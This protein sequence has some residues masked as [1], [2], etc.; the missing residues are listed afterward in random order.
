MST[1]I[2][3]RLKTLEIQSPDT[4]LKDSLLLGFDTETTGTYAGKDAIVSASLVLRNPQT[5]YAGDTV[6]EWIIAP[7]IPMNPLASKVNGFT[8]DFLEAHGA[9]QKTAILEITGTIVQ[10]QLKNIPLLAYNAP[11]DVD[12]LNG[13]L[14]RIGRAPIV[15]EI[16]DA[17]TDNFLTGTQRELI[18]ADPLVIDRAVS[19]RSGRR[20]LT[21]TTYYYGVQPHGSFH[22]ATA[23]TVAAVDLIEPICAAYPQVGVITVAGLMDW[24]RNAHETWK[25][26]FNAYL[27]SQG[28]PPVRDSW[29][30]VQR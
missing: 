6:A 11:F 23:D 9:D 16:N 28:R 24:Q 1:A 14:R 12:M 8:D 19:K 2:L 15:T 27:E 30:P 25:E 4:P 10:A 13:D 20:T 5:G 17:D 22:D 18:V 21:D 7:G 26:Q 3:E 29:F